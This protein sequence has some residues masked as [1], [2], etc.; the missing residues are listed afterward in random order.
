MN[1]LS[2]VKVRLRICIDLEPRQTLYTL[3]LQGRIR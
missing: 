2:L 3:L 1:T